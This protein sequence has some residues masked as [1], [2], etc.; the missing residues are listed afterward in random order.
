M[1]SENIIEAT[2][3]IDLSPLLATNS[4]NS[5]ILTDEDKKRIIADFQSGLFQAYFYLNEGHAKIGDI[6]SVAAFVV[7]YFSYSTWQ[8][9]VLTIADFW[10]D[11]TLDEPRQTDLVEQFRRKLFSVA[12]DNNCKRINFHVKDLEHNQILLKCLQKFGMVNLT[13]DE[14]WNFFQLGGD[15]LNEF[16]N[17]TPGLSSNEFR[18]IKVDDM[19]LYASQIHGHIHEL[20]VFENL[21]DQFECSIEG[22]SKP[23]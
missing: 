23:N 8:N 6:D 3:E 20:S 4:T 14:D 21:E 15:E 18:I 5:T 7:T 2:S 22:W 1:R 9:R 13:R 11:A 17:D 12:R 19:N 16:V 10:L